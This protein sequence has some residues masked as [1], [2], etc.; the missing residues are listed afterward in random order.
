MDFTELMSRPPR[1]LSLE[2][3][4]AFEWKARSCDSEY[5]P[6]IRGLKDDKQDE[7]EEKL[8]HD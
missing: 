7:Q 5:R 2:E 1:R 6:F 3:Q 4:K 8:L